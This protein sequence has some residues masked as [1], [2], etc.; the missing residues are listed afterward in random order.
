MVELETSPLD[1]GDYVTFADASIVTIDDEL[2]PQGYVTAP[3]RKPSSESSA[4]PSESPEEKER[5]KGALVAGAVFGMLLGGPLFSIV[6]GYGA[7]YYVKKEGAKGDCA[8]A[9]GDIALVVRDKA[10]QINARYQY[11]DRA[12]AFANKQFEKFKPAADTHYHIQ[13]RVTKIVSFRWVTTMDFVRE[14]QLLEKASAK[15]KTA[16]VSLE[17]YLSEEQQKLQGDKVDKKKN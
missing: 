17:K 2:S 7:A 10:K 11:T 3:Y 13:E 6:L 9:L 5:N 16:L 12:K 4:G 8:R 15:F 14:H 1:S